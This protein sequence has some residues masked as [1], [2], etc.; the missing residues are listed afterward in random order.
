MKTG[1]VDLEKDLASAASQAVLVIK[2][3]LDEGK[4]YLTPKP[5][6]VGSTNTIAGVESMGPV[7]GNSFEFT[8]AL[9]KFTPSISWWM[10]R[11]VKVFQ[12]M[13]GN[14]GEG[15]GFLLFAGKFSNNP[16]KQGNR[17]ILTCV[18]ESLSTQFLPAGTQITASSHPQAAPESIGKYIP[19]VYGTIKNH[20]LLAT[21]QAAFSSLR[22]TVRKGD[23]VIKLKEARHFPEA[24]GA[25]IDGV[26]YA[27]ASRSE[28]ELYG[29]Q[30]A[31]NHYAGTQVSS[32]DETEYTAAEH[33]LTAA[34]HFRGRIE[35]GSVEEALSDT[36][37][38]D[39]GEGT[40]TF[41]GSPSIAQDAGPESLT[42]NF[43]EVADDSTA[44][45]AINAIQAAT[46]T[47]TQTST[48]N[49][50]A[51]SDD[52][53]K[54]IVFGE[55][56]VIG[57]SSRII[58]GTYEVDF[59]VNITT[60]TPDNGKVTVLIGSA[61]AWVWDGGKVIYDGSPLTFEY[62]KD[63]QEVPVSV[64]LEN[65]AS[66]AFKVD[67]LSAKRTVVTGNLDQAAFATLR[68]SDNTVFS[69]DQTTDHEQSGTVAQ[70]QL[71][72][73][74]FTSADA[75]DQVDVYF[76]E[77]KLGTLT[78]ENALTAQSSQHNIA[79][80]TI[81]E[82]TAELISTQVLNA[83][84]ST[85]S[86]TNSAVSIPITVPISYTVKEI[87]GTPSQT[88]VYALDTQFALPE[89]LIGGVYTFTVE[90]NEAGGGFNNSSDASLNGTIFTPNGTSQTV[91]INLQNNQTSIQVDHDTSF[92]TG[93]GSISTYLYP[94]I[95][96]I[97]G[98]VLSKPTENSLTVTG[99]APTGSVS[100][101]DGTSSISGLDVQPNVDGTGTGDL[102]VNL[103]ATP[104]TVFNI[105]DLSGVRGWSDLSDKNLRLEYNGTG[106]ADVHII[107]AYIAVDYD[108]TIYV[109]AESVVAEITGK[110]GKPADVMDDLLSTAGMT[111]EASS[112]AA[113]KSHHEENSYEIAR[114]IHRPTDI[115]Y[116]LETAAEQSFSGFFHSSDGVKLFSH[117]DLGG[118]VTS[119]TSKDVL[120]E[121]V[122][123]P[124][125]LE[126]V[127]NAILLS[128]QEDGGAYGKSLY[129]DQN[130]P[131]TYCSS[132][133]SISGEDNLVEYEAGWIQGDATATQFLDT[134]VAHRALPRFQVRL[135]LPYS[136][137]KL[138][139]GDLVYLAEESLLVRV[140]QLLNE[141][142]W[143][144]CRGFTVPI[145]KRVT[146]G[147]DL[148]IAE[149]ESE[150]ILEL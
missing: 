87:T 60:G 24:G 111:V 42:V 53:D 135:S 37:T 63:V 97:S 32:S 80:D 130:T 122:I 90:M 75:V 23:T 44:L 6:K 127:E 8:L 95:K 66:L 107:R 119:I 126:E 117:S 123:T 140:T 144:T 65:A 110:S 114:C 1:S 13:Q 113:L 83:L 132:S 2:A 45:N 150:R 109:P 137:S 133:A 73:E 101:Q 19:A 82:G 15:D 56:E 64:Q 11:K 47:Q 21:E 26:T 71:V 28:N 104:R 38:I 141:N 145:V 68:K 55:P 94:T 121:P 125:S 35:N 78:A 91:N 54:F 92:T 57:G 74:H 134:Y 25:I 48:A 72:I 102:T 7:E 33:A 3:E 142:G 136:F 29:L 12:L 116:L 67:V 99:G 14:G 43:D 46:S 18:A 88:I 62:N 129:V 81:S 118:T 52:E 79:I 128:Y 4:Y 41:T 36:P 49:P 51:V 100:V 10:N 5:F 138:D 86:Q 76:D 84:T 106:T 143:I 70:S 30:I 89:G 22:A 108:R 105:F 96:S 77:T 39:L 124:V 27:Y 139:I 149:D 61:I 59:D 98:T 148:K 147:G 103:P 112:K 31:R 17:L 16:V 69:V 40:L 50:K 93:T 34:T 20:H 9:E 85:I 120:A 115:A 58:N 131:N 146:E